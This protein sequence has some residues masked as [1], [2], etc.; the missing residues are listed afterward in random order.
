MPKIKLHGKQVDISAREKKAL[1]AGI[2][3]EAI[4][5]IKRAKRRFMFSDGV[6]WNV[7]HALEYIRHFSRPSWVDRGFTEYND[8]FCPY[9]GRLEKL[10]ERMAKGKK[11]P[12]R[13]LD[14][15][16]GKGV[17]L[18]QIKQMLK[19]SG[20][21]TETIAI[22]LDAEKE[23]VRAKQ[24]GEVDEIAEGLAHKSLP[25]KPVDAIFSYFGSFFYGPHSLAKE[26]LLKYA[27][28]LAP[29][30]IACLSLEV[31]YASFGSS[32]KLRK[33]HAS[34][35]LGDHEKLSAEEKKRVGSLLY[36]WKK[37]EMERYKG[38]IEKSFEKRGFKA[39]FH[40]VPDE[41]KGDFP[42]DILIIRRP[43]KRK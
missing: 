18:V 38:Q 3:K 4:T 23:L 22:T 19:R 34:L 39:K 13:I 7:T 5:Q 31:D 33:Y 1:S 25:S 9:V 41:K 20:V 14:D 24:R 10:L 40:R 8:L 17:F 21:S 37:S 11:R 15:G 32:E 12:L 6:S 42:R 43:K 2:P 28:S 29:G 30:G 26:N 16:A 35:G 27:Y 36:K